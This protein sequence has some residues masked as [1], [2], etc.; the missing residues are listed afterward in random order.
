MV[1][2]YFNNHFRKIGPEG[3]G[4]HGM[5]NISFTENWRL[6][7]AVSNMYCL[8]RYT[9]LLEKTEKN[10]RQSMWL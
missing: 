2:Y 7:C 6:Y 1:F 3:F 10:N 4:L 5:G 9:T 8:D